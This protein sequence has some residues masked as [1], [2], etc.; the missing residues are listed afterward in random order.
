M[1]ERVIKYDI[2]C[3]MREHCHPLKRLSYCLSLL[4]GALWLQRR[5][6]KEEMTHTYT[7]SSEEVKTLRTQFCC[8]KGL[9]PYMFLKCFY[10]LLHVLHVVHMFVAAKAD[11]QTDVPLFMW[12]WRLFCTAAESYNKWPYNTLHRIT[13][14]CCLKLIQP[15]LGIE[16]LYT[17]KN[18]T[19]FHQTELIKWCITNYE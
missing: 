17:D 4:N 5:I 16:C 7:Y 10:M 14:L 18:M 6:N 8:S 15:N 1:A 3:R 19:N 12:N 2:F 11:T 13:S 9:P